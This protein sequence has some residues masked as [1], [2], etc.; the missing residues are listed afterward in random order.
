MR[1]SGTDDG[2]SAPPCSDGWLV[3]AADADVRLIAFRVV[4]ALLAGRP[5]VFRAGLLQ[6]ILRALHPVGIVAMDGK[7][8]PALLHHAFIALG[9]VLGDSHP[10]QGPNDATDD[11]AGACARERAHDRPRRDEWSKT[12]NR[13]CADTGQETQSAAYDRA[14]RR[15]RG[16]AL[17]RLGVLLGREVL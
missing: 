13:E 14:A 9:F 4:G 6:H 16:C 12:W 8:H 7:Q 10:H 11:P 2:S 17:R 15:A 3:G 5:D 1:G